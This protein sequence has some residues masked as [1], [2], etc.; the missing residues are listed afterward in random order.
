MLSPKNKYF[1]L[2]DGK[3]GIRTDDSNWVHLSESALQ[4]TASEAKCHPPTLNK[5]M[6]QAPKKVLGH[7]PPITRGQ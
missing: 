6:L 7:M 2:I 4:V 5:K 1:I 3:Q